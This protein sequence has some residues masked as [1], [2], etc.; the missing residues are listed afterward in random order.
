MKNGILA[1]MALC[2]AT[3]STVPLWAAEYQEPVLKTVEPNLATDGTGGGVYYVYHM[4]SKSFLTAGNKYGTQLSVGENGMKIT[5]DY[6][7]ERAPLLGQKPKV[8]GTGWIFNMM[9]APTNS[10]FHE[11]YLTDRTQAWVDCN[12]QGHT[13]WDIQKQENGTYRI[14]VVKQDTVYS[15][16]EEG[17]YVE[18]MWGVSEGS[19]AVLPTANPEEGGYENAAVDWAF[20][21]DEYYELYKAKKSLYTELVYADEQGFTE[22]SSYERLYDSNDATADE[23]LRAALALRQ[24][25]M[26]KQGEG[27]TEENPKDFTSMIINADL[28]NGNTGW[29]DDAGSAGLGHQDGTSYQDADD[30][31]LLMEHFTEEWQAANKGGVTAR[32]HQVLGNMPSGRYRLSAKTIGYNQ[33][34]WQGVHHGLYLFAETS[35]TGDEYRAEAHTLKFGGLAN[36]AQKDDV[37]SPRP[38]VLEFYSRGGDLTIGLK[39]VN[40]NCNWIAM[41]DVRL[42]YLGIGSGMA[43]E[44]RASVEKLQQR[45]DEYTTNNVEISKAGAQHARDLMESALK[46]AETEMD[47]GAL[48]LVNKSVL[49]ELEVLAADAAAY[50]KLNTFLS[51]VSYW[52]GDYADLA[53][54]ALDDY[55]AGLENAQSD[56]TF[57]PADA[58]SLQVR[59]DRLF[60]QE[61]N[62]AI[63]SGETDQIT[64]LL[65]NPSFARNNDGWTKTGNGNYGND[66]HHIGEVWNGRDWEVFQ[67]LTGLPEGFYKITMQ[68]FYSPSSPNS[69]VW[70]AGWGVEG[71]VINTPMAYVFANSAAELMH[72]VADFPQDAKMNENGWEEISG[73][74]D[75]NLN[76]KFLPVNMTAS[77]TVFQADEN[78]YLNTVNCY[79]GADGVLRIGTRLAGVTRDQAWVT[80]DNFK[81]RYLGFE[82]TQS[83]VAALSAKIKEAE[84]ALGEGALMT[85]AVQENLAGVVLAA[86]ELIKGE[87]SGEQFKSTMASLEEAM[88]LAKASRELVRSADELV[89]KHNNASDDGMYDGYNADDMSLLMDYVGELAE[90]IEMKDLADDATVEAYISDIRNAYAD[91]LKSAVDMTVASKDEPVDVTSLIQSASFSERVDD[92]T[93]QA[94]VDGWTVTNG[95]RNATGA[96]NYEFYN[97]TDG[98]IRQTLYGMPKGYYRVGYNGTYRAGDIAPA[99]VAYRAGTDAKNASAYVTVGGKTV[100]EPLPSMFE[101]VKEG[102]YHANDVVLHDTLRV[103]DDFVYNCM[104]NNVA[105]AD[106]AFSHGSYEGSITFYVDED[107]QDVTIGVRKDGALQNDWAIIDNFRLYYFGDGEAN[108]PDAIGEVISGADVFV[109]SSAWYTINGVR[110]AEPRQQGIYIREDLLSDGSKKAVKVIV[111]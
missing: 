32:I 42:E 53:L 72:H 15:R 80:F 9:D 83:A 49:A 35:S 4:A 27:A 111:K 30:E 101:G 51:N 50:V 68:G 73:T 31:S 87:V 5:L 11:V 6:G 10:G 79:V 52:D 76:G 77:G 40:T 45:L 26:D 71:D 107:K 81:V 86:T 34:D 75:A 39:T 70:H 85:V 3:S 61:I 24:A 18:R 64:G 105:G 69:G 67:E 16:N 89:A 59:A 47:D 44:V 33:G 2:C 56:L 37:P 12:E 14:M 7:T 91:M 28:N 66:G 43:G 60:R 93:E 62:K 58:D 88:A 19:T 109:V 22:V 57:D 17:E 74:A 54:P 82:N 99:A 108:N 95:S 8:D 96:K 94:S 1:A 106:A 104:M 29:S 55:I 110:V 41:D 103:N 84:R 21:T 36:G 38:V 100:S 20:T 13:L 25:V 48:S 63:E 98:D 92:I 65:V 78:N 23:V 102:K 46:A 90:M 97:V